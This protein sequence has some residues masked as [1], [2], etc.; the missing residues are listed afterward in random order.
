MNVP[1]VEKSLGS[2]HM[3]LEVIKR[4]GKKVPFDKDKIIK[5]IN[6]AY[7]SVYPNEQMPTPAIIIA[8]AVEEVARAY[9]GNLTVEEII[10]VYNIDS[11]LS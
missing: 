3:E 11:I 10:Y 5:A 1:I 9:E 8:D 2:E 7:E 4:S 6:K